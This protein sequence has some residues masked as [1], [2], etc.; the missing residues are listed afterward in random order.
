MEA[1]AEPEVVLAAAER[2]PPAAERPQPIAKRVERRRTSSRPPTPV[3]G[4]GKVAL[5]ISPWAEVLHGGKSLGIT[6][7]AAVTVPSGRQTFT[8]RNSDLGIT[9]KVTVTV[10][11]N[12]EV[13]LRADL[14]DAP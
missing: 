3:R 1:K 14:F 4:E 10:P 12:G 11:V 13:E 6:P 7:M 8:L 5:R 9:R 2:A